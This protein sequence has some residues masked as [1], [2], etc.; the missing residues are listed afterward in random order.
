MSFKPPRPLNLVK[1]KAEILAAAD[2]AEIVLIVSRHFPE[3]DDSEQVDEILWQKFM[4][5]EETG[6]DVSS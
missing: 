6:D 4:S 1:L 5:Y 3:A 2:V